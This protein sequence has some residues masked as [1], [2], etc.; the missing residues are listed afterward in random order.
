MK[1]QERV[2]GPSLVSSNRKESMIKKQVRIPTS[3]RLDANLKAELEKIR[4]ET[5]TPIVFIVN[6]A[7]REWIHKRNGWKG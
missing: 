1:L 7:V 4:V 5:G 3:I 6:K 2:F